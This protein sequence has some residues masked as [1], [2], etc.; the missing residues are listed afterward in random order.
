MIMP[1]E[2]VPYEELP[3]GRLDPQRIEALW[4]YG[5]TAAR[6]Q[7]V[8]PDG[9][10]DLVAHCTLTPQKHIAAVWLAVA[11]PADEPARVAAGADRMSFGVR[12]RIGWGGACLGVEP[13]TLR[14]RVVVG[15]DAERLLGAPAQVLLGAR[16]LQELREALVHAAGMIG[17]RPRQ[18]TVGQARALQ[19]ISSLQHGSGPL[20]GAVQSTGRTL[21]RDV[22]AAAGLPLRSL[23]GI[24][25]FQRAMA[26]LHAG[27]ADSLCELA[28]AAG[29]SDQ[30]HMTRE[31]RRFGGFTPALPQAAPIIDAVVPQAAL[32]HG[33]NLQ[34]L[35]I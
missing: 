12:F 7:L 31:F 27:T 35:C 28:L 11:G 2:P 6:R 30:A 34:D 1:V 19:A 17:S 3:L 9:R 8:L 33:R 20:R 4:C 10:M 23:A 32:A 14:N 22:L 21:R 24:L 18:P 26:M 5:A 16:S 25:R 13:A 15:R 29:Y